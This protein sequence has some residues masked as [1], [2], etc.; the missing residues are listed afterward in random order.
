MKTAEER[1]AEALEL[2]AD[3]KMEEDETLAKLALLFKGYARDQRHAD[4]ERGQAAASR[5][6]TATEVH[7]AIMNTPF[8]GEG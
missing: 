8:P 5:F 1:A 6:G 7:R 2:A 4:A 3:P